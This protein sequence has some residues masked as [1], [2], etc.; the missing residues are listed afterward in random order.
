MDFMTDEL[1]TGQRIRLLTLVDNFSRES[2]AIEVGEHIGS[3]QVVEVRLRS[4]VNN[5]HQT[6]H[7]ASLTSASCLA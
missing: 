7:A 1:C 3:E 4:D 2:L 5:V 6:F